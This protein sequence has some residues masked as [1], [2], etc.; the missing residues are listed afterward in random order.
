ML[1]RSVLAFGTYLAYS[2]YIVTPVKAKRT[3]APRVV[4]PKVA[5]NVVVG[6]STYEEEWIPEHVI[7]ELKHRKAKVEKLTSGSES[8]GVKK[9]GKK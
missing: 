5:A 8:E 3:R 4:V 9:K 7:R 1:F 6:Q 2:S